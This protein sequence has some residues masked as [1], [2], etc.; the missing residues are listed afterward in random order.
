MFCEVQRLYERGIKKGRP[1]PPVPGELNLRRWMDGLGR[2][3]MRLRAEL[4]RP[5]GDSAIPVMI[6]ALVVKI[7]ESGIIVMGTELVPRG[8]KSKSNVEYY[9]QTWWCRVLTNA[10]KPLHPREGVEGPKP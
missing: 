1:L 10:K 8:S 3:S 7:T 4:H 6:D 9:K 2:N 5:S